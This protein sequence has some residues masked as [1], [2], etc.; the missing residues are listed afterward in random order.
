MTQKINSS[1]FIL[2]SSI[3]CI[4]INVFASFWFKRIDFTVDQRYTL[5][6]TSTKLMRKIKSPVVI[7]I[8]LDGDLNPD[9]NKLKNEVVALLEEYKTL[10]SYVNIQLMDPLASDDMR[11]SNIK[12]LIARGLTPLELSTK[13][14]GKL[15]QQLIFPW[16]LMSYNNK[17]TKINLLKNNFNASEQEIITASIQQLEFIFTDG[18]K[19]LITDREDQNK[20]AVLKGNGQLNDIY[21]ADYLKT[22]GNH[23]RLAEFTL[24]SVQNSPLKTLNQ[25]REYDLIINAKPTEAF[26]EKEKYVLDQFIMNGGKSIWLTEGAIINRDSLMLQKESLIIPRELNLN[27]LFFSYGFRI[28]RNLITSRDA[29]LTAIVSGQGSQ[30]Q[31]IPRIFPYAILAKPAEKHT[32]TKNIADV[33]FEFASQIDTLKNNLKKTILLQ[34]SKNTEIQGL[35][36]IVSL[37]QTLNSIT[38]SNF[39]DGAQNLAVL[40]EGKIPSAYQFR[41]KP[42]NNSEHKDE[43]SANSMI[44]VSCGNVIKNELQRGKPAELG[45]DKWSGITYGN[46]E[47]L[48]NAVN[49]LLDDVGLMNIRNKDIQL[50]YLNPELISKHKGLYKIVNILI[51]VALIL[52]L[53][54]LYNLYLR[55]KYIN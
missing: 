9:F 18:L 32:I 49:Y 38:T 14:D 10:N 35:P 45:F 44:I 27:E 17:T 2:I 42:F 43:S 22:L 26:S 54:L 23:Y 48:L 15:A 11:E 19:K 36:K 28:N 30:R 12:Q 55:K 34:S 46:K 21:I 40:L 52:L 51:P 8:F 5:S 41:V 25:L 16:A 29:A 37:E 13:K 4:L 31:F 1:Y 39:N 3:A 33:K 24:D 6:E 50:G 7:D 20:I 47:F 53:G